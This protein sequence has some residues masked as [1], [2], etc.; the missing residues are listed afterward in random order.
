MKFNIIK[1]NL[2]L[3][4]KNKKLIAFSMLMPF[5]LMIL[6]SIIFDEVKDTKIP[7]SIIDHD[8]SEM[9]KNFVDALKK[10]TSIRVNN[11]DPYTNLKNNHIE[12]IL[13][14]TE[15]FEEKI[16]ATN[17]IEVLELV[18]L[19]KSVIAPAISDI[20]ASEIMIP[21]MIH[22]ANNK[23]KTYENSKDVLEIADKLVKEN[24]FKMDIESTVKYP[25]KDV[26]EKNISDILKNSVM[27]GYSIMILSFIIMFISSYIINNSIRNHLLITYSFFNIFISDLLSILI[28]GFLLFLLILIY[29]KAS[30]IAIIAILLH[31][32][33]IS[34]LVLLI[35][36]QTSKIRYQSITTPLLFILGVLGG[37]FWSIE[38]LNENIRYICMIS[39]IYWTLG[40]INNMIE[41]SYLSYY[42]LFNMLFIIT[43]YFIT[44]RKGFY[45]N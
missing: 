1:V 9:S 24:H 14:I 30:I 20:I 45:E 23:S 32:I 27:Y 17:Y 26:V 42:I 37:A 2:K 7:I 21:L 13:I 25:N 31:S 44:R 15:G 16:K 3:F 6:F 40:I 10:N 33:F 34:T 41:S 38:L 12:G 5:L 22:K 39:P 35:A 36:Y 8:Q 4:L 29:L 11:E 28:A 19:D 43:T 18:Y